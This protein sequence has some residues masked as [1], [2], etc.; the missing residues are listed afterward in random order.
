MTETESAPA[1][2][3]VVIVE[4]HALLREGWSRC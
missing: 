2:I 4:D 1:E 3:R